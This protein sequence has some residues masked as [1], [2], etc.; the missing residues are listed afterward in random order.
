MHIH[1]EIEIHAR[2]DDVWD[3]L[4]DVDSYPTWNPYHVH[5]DVDGELAAGQ[6]LVVEIHKP[7]GDQV[8]IRPHVL[9][10]ERGR[11]LT[12][13]GGPRRIFRGEHTF[14][15]EPTATGTRLIHSEVFSGFAVRFASLDSIE[16]GYTAMNLALK[17]HL[18]IAH[19]TGPQA[20]DRSLLAG[21]RQ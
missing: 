1:T 13:G 7:N 14:I 18:E 19:R 6:R 8:T 12:W 9:R 2:P 20:E 11:E 21:H 17:R 4:V 5:V 15:V 10:L 3:A 16:E